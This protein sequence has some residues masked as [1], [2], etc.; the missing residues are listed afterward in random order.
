MNC[1]KV[2]RHERLPRLHW[3]ARLITRVKAD[4]VACRHK[5]FFFLLQNL[6]HVLSIAS[7]FCR[8]IHFSPF[9]RGQRTG[10]IGTILHFRAA[11]ERFNGLSSVQTARKFNPT[12]PHRSKQCRI[13]W[14]TYVFLFIIYLFFLF[15][16]CLSL[17]F[18]FRFFCWSPGCLT[19]NYDVWHNCHWI[20]HTSGSQ[21]SVE[22]DEIM[23]NQFWSR[24]VT[25][26]R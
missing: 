7:T 18:M 14:K 1:D 13:A 16:S 19:R 6:L 25:R 21:S 10:T 12:Q 11:L 23:M 5:W 22:D 24:A 3:P 17:C 26:E 9:I 8:A 4:A 15:S 20:P 2:P